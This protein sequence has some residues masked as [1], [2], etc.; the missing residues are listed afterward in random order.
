MELVV[1][2]AGENR[3][4]TMTPC[5]WL[6]GPNGEVIHLNVGRSRGKLMRCKFCNQNYRQ[7]DGKLCDFTV[8]EGKPCDAAMCKSCAVTLG[9][10]MV[11]VGVGDFTKVD[12]IDVCPIHKDAKVVNGKFVMEEPQ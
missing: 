1:G 11:P 3:W 2:D 5:E 10:Q 12:S 4:R 8:A 6:K 9:G 7:N